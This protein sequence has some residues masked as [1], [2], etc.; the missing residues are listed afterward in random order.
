MLTKSGIPY[1]FF[2][3]KIKGVLLPKFLRFKTGSLTEKIIFVFVLIPILAILIYG[4]YQSN[5]HS[6][7]L[8]NT[9]GIFYKDI[10]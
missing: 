1:Y 2:P 5:Q 8:K 7:F 3:F 10:I 9:L 4:I 6:S